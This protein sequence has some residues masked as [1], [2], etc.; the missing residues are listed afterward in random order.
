[1][2]KVKAIV[3]LVAIGLL[4]YSSCKKEEVLQSLSSTIWLSTIGSQTWTLS[5]LSDTNFV[6]NYI[7]ASNGDTKTSSGVYTYTPPTVV[8]TD[9]DNISETGTVSVNKITFPTAVFVKK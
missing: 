4:T 8:I 7:D 2:I 3:I 9:D 6:I 1:M 5:F